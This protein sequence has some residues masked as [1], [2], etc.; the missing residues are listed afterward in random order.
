MSG[1]GDER[2][3]FLFNELFV[4]GSEHSVLSFSEGGEVFVF[5][6]DLKE[7]I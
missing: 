7:R 3:S 1:F 2:V 5:V 4:I 6:F